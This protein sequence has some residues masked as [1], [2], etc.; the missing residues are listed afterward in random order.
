MKT[1]ILASGCFW[2]T[3]YYLKRVPGVIQTR[4]GYTGGKTENPSYEQVC[5]GGTGHVEAVE[6]VYDPQ[7][8]SYEKLLK[9]FF[10]THDPTQKDGQ[11]PDIG[12]QYRSVI[13]YADD[14]ERSIAQNL[15]EFLKGKGLKIA[16]R[17]QLTQKFWPAGL[18]HQD[19][20]KKSKGTPYCHTYHKIF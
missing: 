7:K 1:A 11:G 13:F 15:I 5:A 12:P 20:Y 3:Q 18:Y 8:I 14:K 16:T 10:E 9:Y 17:L 2:G 4:V 19:Y 6:V